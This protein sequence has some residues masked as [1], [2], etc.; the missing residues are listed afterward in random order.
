MKRNI[1][2]IHAQ[3]SPQKLM[4]YQLRYQVLKDTGYDLAQVSQKMNLE[5]EEDKTAR[6]L[7]A[8]NNDV[9]VGTLTLDWWKHTEI[10]PEK[11][12]GFQFQ[13][14][15][16]AF[17]KHSVFLIRKTVVLP[18]YRG[19]EAF[20]NLIVAISAFILT[21]P[22]PHFI[23]LDCAHELSAFYHK[24]GFRNY[25]PAFVYPDGSISEPMCAVME[26][27]E[28]FSKN[29]SML[30]YVAFTHQIKHEQ[31]VADFFERYWPGDAEQLSNKLSG[32]G[33]AKTLMAV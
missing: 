18:G 29:R 2:V 31:N 3:T 8:M 16:K 20:W 13:T 12:A 27:M 32:A 28:Y 5:E 10:P 14:F 24:L 19:S 11:I 15:E 25:A 9:P 26:D 1:S 7:V 4:A 33:K 17:S 21:K 22:G 23:F 30:R 6:I